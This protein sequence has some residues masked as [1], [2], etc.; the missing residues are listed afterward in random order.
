MERI[1]LFSYGTLQQDGVQLATFGRML[2]GTPD[3]LAGHRLAPLSISDPDVIAL[4][5]KGVH[6]IARCTGNPLDRIAG[7]VFELIAAELAASD[8]YEVDAYERIELT[9]ESGRRAWVY[10]GPPRAA[11]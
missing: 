5:G 10:V 7:V 3:V 6:T 9:L 2:E 11:A 8:S 1:L 4:S